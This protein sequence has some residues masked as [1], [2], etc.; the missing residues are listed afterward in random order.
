MRFS[1]AVAASIV[2]FAAALFGQSN[3]VPFVNQPLVPATVAPGS[4]AFTLTVNGT[5]FVSGSVVNWNASARATTFV[6]SSQLTAT[7]LATDVA[8]A[9]TGT[10]TVTSPAP[11]GGVSNPVYLVVTNPFRQIT[12]ASSTFGA[13]PVPLW[14][15]GAD[16]NGDG[17]ID[18]ITAN[19]NGTI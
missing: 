4:P 12:F 15:T 6:N 14:M 17:K 7:V 16:L 3:P 2:V 5:G 18:L 19:E 13:P 11:G 10:V 1:F 9:E 8:V